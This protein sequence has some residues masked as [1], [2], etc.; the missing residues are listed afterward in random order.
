MPKGNP[1]AFLPV[2][3]T[4]HTHREEWERKGDKWGRGVNLT[5]ATAKIALRM[6]TSMDNRQLT[7]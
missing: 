5:K 2:F 6:L 7:V 1:L 3:L 4:P